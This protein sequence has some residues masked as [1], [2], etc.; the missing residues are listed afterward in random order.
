MLLRPGSFT[1]HLAHAGCAVL[2][3]LHGF[4]ARNTWDWYLSH[5]IY[6]VAI[7]HLVV[8][9]ASFQ[10]PARLG[11]K[12]DIPKLTRFNQ[13]IFWV[14]G[15]ILLCIVS[16]AAVIWRL[17]DAFLA[18]EPAARRLH[19][20]I[21]DRPNP[22]DLFW[23]D[24]RD[25]PQGKCHC[26]RSRIVDQPLHARR[27]L[28]VRRTSARRNSLPPAGSPVTA[29]SLR[30]SRREGGFRPWHK[31]GKPSPEEWHG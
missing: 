4:I 16:F 9:I 18:G 19:C 17:H 23:Y 11:W 27:G 20:H 30:E 1:S 3:W 7:G 29:G 8:L 14:Y 28:L 6:A 2:L 24:H 26:G 12:Q 10:A 31:L 15:F 25:W 13:K 22:T 5:A 21:L